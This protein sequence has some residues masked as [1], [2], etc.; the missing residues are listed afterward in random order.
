MFPVLSL[1][2]LDVGVTVINHDGDRDSKLTWAPRRERFGPRLESRPGA[3]KGN[4]VELS[5]DVCG[6]AACLYDPNDADVCGNF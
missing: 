5:M 4:V 3:V 2:S 1:L 6:C